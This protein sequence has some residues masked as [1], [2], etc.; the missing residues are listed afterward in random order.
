MKLLCKQPRCPY[1]IELLEWFETDT[2]FILILERPEP[3]VTLFDYCRSLQN[4]V[5]DAQAQSIMQQLVKALRHCHDRGV[6][7]RDMKLDNILSNIQTME[8]KLIDFGFSFL[9][10]DT[11]CT[12]C[13]ATTIIVPKIWIC[14]DEKRAEYD[15]I[16]DLGLLLLSM[17]CGGI[18]VF[19]D[20]LLVFKDN[21][22]DGSSSSSKDL[23]TRQACL[24]QPPGSL[25]EFA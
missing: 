4:Q 23:R 1:V 22:S 3:C 14:E 20:D 7:H 13:D 17:L 15:V 11:T 12:E 19:D 10:K 16:R 8:V 25:Y 2:A 9:R 21:L 5:P 18:H 6:F 24:R